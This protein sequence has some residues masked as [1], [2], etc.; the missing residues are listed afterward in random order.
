MAQAKKSNSAAKARAK[1]RQVVP[2]M[3]GCYFF[4]YNNPKYRAH[5]PA[6]DAHPLIYVL[7][8]TKLHTLSINMHW[9]KPIYRKRFVDML[10]KA[11][12]RFRNK[13]MFVSWVYE[14]FKTDPKLR[15]VK[16]AIRKYLNNRIRNIQV[17]D[18]DQLA[19]INLRRTKYRPIFKDGGE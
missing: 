9:I 16:Q 5:L 18:R 11:S 4:S 19:N 15:F 12:E 10:N 1:R 13:R 6:F 7:D 8:V 14:M 3:S 2:G 17:V